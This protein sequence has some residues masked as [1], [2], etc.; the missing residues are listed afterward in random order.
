MNDTSKTAEAL[1]NE[2][3]ALR[4]RIAEIEALKARNNCLEK[5]VETLKRTCATIMSLE[6]PSPA[7]APDSGTVLVVEDNE[8][9]RN[10]TVMILRRHG[11]ETL[12]AENAREAMDICREEGERIRLLL[13]DIVM[14]EI[15]GGKLVELLAPLNL[16]IK[17]LY[18]SGYAR[19]DLAHQDVYDIIDSGASFIQKP[20]SAG[21][22][23]EKLTAVLEPA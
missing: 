10:F 14:P 20:F 18:M 6:I 4:K 17:I 12:E 5:E 19:D 21:E 23:M 15:G 3:Q 13:T 2:V 16:D 8:L 11:F 7:V 9:F 22:L 1:E